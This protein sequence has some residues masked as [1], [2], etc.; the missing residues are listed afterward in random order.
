VIGLAWCGLHVATFRFKGRPLA[1]T[2][3]SINVAFQTVM[4]LVL[5]CLG[6]ASL[7]GR[8]PLAA[9]WF[10][11]KILL[12]GVVFLV[13]VGIDTKFQPFTMLLAAGRE[14][15]TPA[16]EHAITRAT[17]QTLAWALLMYALILA[18]AYL[19]VLKPF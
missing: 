18:I 12:F 1:K 11:G 2:L 16:A 7:A 3:R 10:A 14:G 6:I 9:S 17:N 4:G 8:G 15:L 19:G 13:V 5:V